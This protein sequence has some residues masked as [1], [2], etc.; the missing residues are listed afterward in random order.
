MKLGFVD[1]YPTYVYIDTNGYYLWDH[2]QKK[3]VPITEKGLRGHIT[4]LDLKDKP[5]R[6]KSVIKLLIGVTTEDKEYVIQ[7]GINS[8]FSKTILIR[9]NDLSSEFLNKPITIGI[10][11]SKSKSDVIFGKIQPAV[12][13]PEN[14]DY[15]RLTEERLISLCVNINDRIKNVTQS[16]RI[17]V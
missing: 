6:G 3:R 2:K 1:L 11:K 17:R 14:F 8:W 13:L 4:G 5:Y 10:Q 12:K 15:S 9:L 7:T 16:R